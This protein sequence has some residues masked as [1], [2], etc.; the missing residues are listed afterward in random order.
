M[1][2]PFF[3][4]PQSLSTDVEGLPAS[5]LAAQWKLNVRRFFC[6]NPVCSHKTFA[7]AIPEVAARSA[8]KTVRLTELL[9]QPGFALDG[10]AGA[11]IATVLNIACSADTFLR[12]MRKTLLASHPT[13]THV[14]VDDWAFRRNV[15]YGT[16]LVDLR[17]HQV[18]VC[19]L[20]DRSATSSSRQLR[21]SG[22]LA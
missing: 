17:D 21:Q 11:P 10:E 19:L 8:R 5:G 22:T 2:Y 16:I 4:N 3:T 6:E 9:K 7:E 15:S 18:V 14:G 20:P 1:L 13:P 12:L